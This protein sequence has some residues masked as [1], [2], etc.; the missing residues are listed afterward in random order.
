MATYDVIMIVVLAGTTLWGFYKGMAWQLAALGALVASYF[1]AYHF[2]DQVAPYLSAVAPWNKF[3]AM[4]LLY[5]ATSASVWI[6]FRY[7]RGAI[8]RVRLREFDRQI[9]GLFGLAKGV[10]LCVVITFFVVTMSPN[11][12]QQVLASKSGYYITVFIHRAEPIMPAEARELLG[13]Y[14]EKLE[15]GLDPRVEQPT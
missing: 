2:A 13:P 11:G 8:E 3:A 12:R 14:L 7:V 10:L 4:L 6:V 15:R 1:V 9:G 5:L